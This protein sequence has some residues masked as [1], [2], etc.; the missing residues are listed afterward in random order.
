[1]TMAMELNNWF[2][3]LIET[4]ENP[5]ENM[6]K[7]VPEY[8][9]V[10]LKTRTD[11]LLDSAKKIFESRNIGTK[12]AIGML[13]LNE[14]FEIQKY[15]ENKSENSK[16]VELEKLYLIVLSKVLYKETEKDNTIEGLL[17]NEDFQRALFGCCLEA[18]LYLHSVVSINFEEV[19]DMCGTTPFDF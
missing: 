5:L 1:M 15:E 4:C 8:L 16:I 10:I 14:N 13:F 19:L 3:D 12:S 17:L 7:T 2:M 6:L 9:S 11:S 18:L